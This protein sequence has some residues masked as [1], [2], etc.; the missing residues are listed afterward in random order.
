NELPDVTA[1]DF[2]KGLVKVKEFVAKEGVTWTQAQTES[3]KPLYE[4]RFQIVAWPTMILLD[5][6]G[7]I[8]SVDRT[9]KGEAGLRGEK[10]AQTIEDLFKK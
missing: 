9:S 2:A 6:D 1:D 10:L 5:R 3:I 8:L 7:K 4:K